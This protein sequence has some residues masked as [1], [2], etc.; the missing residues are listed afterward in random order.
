VNLARSAF[1][2]RE[3]SAAAMPVRLDNIRRALSPDAQIEEYL[4]LAADLATMQTHRGRLRS[5]LA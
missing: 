5:G 1:R 2:M 4:Q 3:K